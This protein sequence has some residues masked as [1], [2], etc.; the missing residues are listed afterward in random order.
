MDQHVSLNAST[1]SVDTY[2]KIIIMI[3]TNYI[4]FN[5]ILL[6]TLTLSIAGILKID[7]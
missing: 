1:R 2:I 3:M 6:F 5:I 4:K 7:L